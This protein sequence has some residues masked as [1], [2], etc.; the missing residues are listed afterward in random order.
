MKDKDA[1]HEN[2]AK[3]D[4]FFMLKLYAQKEHRH[5]TSIDISVQRVNRKSLISD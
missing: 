2:V 5:W 4:E 1:S 3:A